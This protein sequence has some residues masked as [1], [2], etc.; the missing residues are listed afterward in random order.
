MKR[1]PLG[2]GS[3]VAAP[4][5]SPFSSLFRA[6]V[7]LTRNLSKIRSKLKSNLDLQGLSPLLSDQR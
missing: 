4:S 6:A 5:M 7:F 1:V 3:S 2:G